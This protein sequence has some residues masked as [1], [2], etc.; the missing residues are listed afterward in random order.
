MSY[1]ESIEG[2]ILVVAPNDDLGKPTGEISVC[3][4]CGSP[5]FQVRWKHAGTTGWICLR[6]TKHLGMGVFQMQVEKDCGI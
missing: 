6:Q 3:D 1:N 5:L 2:V 4:S